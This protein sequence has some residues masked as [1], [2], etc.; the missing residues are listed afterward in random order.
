[1][2]YVCAHMCVHLYR[3]VCRPEVYLLSVF[4]SHSPSYPLR[5]ALSLNLELAMLTRLSGQEVLGT[6]LV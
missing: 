1:M 3:H 2:V 5:Q 6:C 4:L